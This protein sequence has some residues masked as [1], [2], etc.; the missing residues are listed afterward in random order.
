MDKQKFKFK[1]S[2]KR[3]RRVRG[4]VV[5]TPDRPR[6]TVFRSA[7][8]TYAQIIDDESGATLVTASTVN[9][10]FVDLGKCGG[11]VEA[12]KV[13]GQ[14][15]ARKALA[16]GIRQVSFDRNGRKFHGRIKALADASREAGLVF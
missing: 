5:G 9:K 7:R 6:L 12:A 2:L 10:E 11:N 1:R 13:V 4:K 15:L 16:V 8:Q 3:K 14:N